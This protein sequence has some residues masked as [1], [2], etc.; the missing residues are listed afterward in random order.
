MSRQYFWNH[1]HIR[2]ITFG[3]TGTMWTHEVAKRDVDHKN[4]YL[5]VSA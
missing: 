5:K 2:N 3:R 4:L 1:Y